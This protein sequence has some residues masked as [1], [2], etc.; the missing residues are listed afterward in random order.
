MSDQDFFDLL[1]RL[2]G[3]GA[4]DKMGISEDKAQRAQKL[5]ENVTSGDDMPDQGE[6]SKVIRDMTS[7]L[8]EEK[9]RELKEF[10]E[11]AAQQLESEQ[12]TD[13][14]L[15]ILYLFLDRT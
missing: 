15:K 12:L 11:Q 2:V 14:L 10:V 4:V 7:N 1:Q 9:C 5:L 6:I 3:T 8:S 13:D